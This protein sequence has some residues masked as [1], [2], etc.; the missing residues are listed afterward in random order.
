M[1]GVIEGIWLTE[2][3]HNDD[4]KLYHIYAGWS[5]VQRPPVLWSCRPL[6]QRGSSGL[7]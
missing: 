5:V 4:A 7:P 2:Y 6:V 3:E 1:E